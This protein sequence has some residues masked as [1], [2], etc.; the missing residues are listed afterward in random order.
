[1]KLK[2]NHV[3]FSFCVSLYFLGGAYAVINRDDR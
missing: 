1:M 2:E 3:D